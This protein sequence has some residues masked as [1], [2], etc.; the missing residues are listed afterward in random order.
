[1]ARPKSRRKPLGTIWEISDELWQRIEPI[2]KEFWPKKPTRRRVANWRKM[3]NAII[4]RS[5]SGC[6][7]DQL[8]ERFGP[9]GTVHDWFQR[10][11]QG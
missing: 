11:V 1:M 4:F 7:W 3:I 8:P 10:W 9:K 2:L 5:R 6:Q